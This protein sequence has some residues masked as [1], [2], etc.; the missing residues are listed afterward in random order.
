[1]EL[2]DLCHAPVPESHHYG[3]FGRFGRVSKIIGQ[4]GVGRDI[5]R[6]YETTSYRN[7]CAVGTR[8]TSR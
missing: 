5:E 3:P 2:R 8:P 1:M 4:A 7:N 6:F